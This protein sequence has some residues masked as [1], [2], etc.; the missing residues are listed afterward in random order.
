MQH[1][2]GLNIETDDLVFEDVGEVVFQFL[3]IYHFYVPV[4]VFSQLSDY[5]HLSTLPFDCHDVHHDVLL[6]RD[7]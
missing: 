6:L 2:L 3:G 4:G 1:Y 5:L 7:S